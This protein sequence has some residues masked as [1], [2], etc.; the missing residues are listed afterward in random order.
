MHWVG[1]WSLT[2]GSQ[3]WEGEFWRVADSCGGL[4]VSLKIQETCRTELVENDLV[5]IC[6]F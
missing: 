2:E 1:E 6:V 4:V 5:V 3:G